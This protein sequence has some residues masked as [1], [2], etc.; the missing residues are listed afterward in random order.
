MFLDPRTESYIDELVEQQGID[1]FVHGDDPCIVDGRD[2]LLGLLLS[3]PPFYVLI[4]YLFVPFSQSVRPTLLLVI[5]VRRVVLLPGFILVTL[6]A[7]MSHSGA[8]VRV[9]AQSRAVLHHTSNR[10]LAR[11][12]TS[13]ET[14]CIFRWSQG[15]VLKGATMSCSVELLSCCCSFFLSFFYFF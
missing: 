4:K 13:P 8:Q 14:F 3:D 5:C 7:Y 6:K 9:G 15:K 1:Y 2:V 11:Y 12:G 10:L